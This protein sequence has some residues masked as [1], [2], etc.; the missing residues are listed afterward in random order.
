M[1]DVGDD[2]VETIMELVERTGIDTKL[3]LCYASIAAGNII[4]GIRGTA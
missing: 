3:L 1:P 4:I 2:V